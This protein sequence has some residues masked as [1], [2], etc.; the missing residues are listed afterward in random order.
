MMCV[1]KTQQLPTR[2]PIL[3]IF[4]T[5]FFKLLRILRRDEV[6]IKCDFGHFRW[7]EVIHVDILLSARH[8]IRHRIFCLCQCG[9]RSGASSSINFSGGSS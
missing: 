6:A 4:A 2:V 9:G 8:R 5:S 7:I 3:R 1:V